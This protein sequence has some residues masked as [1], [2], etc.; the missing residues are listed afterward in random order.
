MTTPGLLADDQASGALAPLPEAVPALRVAL[1]DARI[2]AVNL[3]LGALLRRQVEDLVGR[4]LSDLWYPTERLA[5]EQRFDDVVLLGGDTFGAIA[6]PA[7]DRS[8]VW[9][10]VEAHFLYRGGQRLEVF[11]HPLTRP[12]E[13]EAPSGASEALVVVPDTPSSVA[14]TTPKDDGHEP[15]DLVPVSVA[16]AEPFL[17][18]TTEAPLA[19]EPHVAIGDVGAPRPTAGTLVAGSAP[20]AIVMAVLEAAG[21]AAL[22][23]SS[24]GVVGS[25]TPESERVLRAPIARLRGASFESLLALS[26]AAAEALRIARAAR[27]RQSVLADLADGQGAVVLE[28]VPA[29]QPGAGYAIFMA[30]MPAS[31]EAERLRLQTRLVSFVSHDVRESLAAVYCGLRMLADEVPADAPQRLTVE[32]VLAESSRANRIVDDVL[33]VSRPGRLRRVDLDLGDVLRDTIA[34]YRAKAASGCVDIREALVPGVLVMADL[35]SLERAFGNLIENALEATPH[36]GTLTITSHLEDRTRPG[37]RVSVSD[38]G[39]G[40]RSDIAPNI[41]EPFVTDKP[42]GTGLGLASTRRIVLDHEGQIDFESEIG[43]GTTFYV[44]LPREDDRVEV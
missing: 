5:L 22:A 26:E 39:V 44:W 37:I 36:G 24:D 29:D 27:S 23:V 19:D 25:A 30:D 7:S 21:A 11:L 17:V 12:A 13:A 8:P 35:A 1:A 14:T 9:V 3:S 41:F 10:E 20:L 32:R 18:T 40:V 43:K 28:W 42:G 16:T 31:E 34:R 6:L 38:T 2:T 4:A 15:Q 33:A